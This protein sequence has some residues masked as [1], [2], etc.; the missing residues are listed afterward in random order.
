MDCK[1]KLPSAL[2]KGYSRKFEKGLE[3]MSP[4]EIKNKLIEFA[5]EHTR[6]AFCLFL[7]AGRGNPNWIATVPREAF[8]LLGKFGLEEC[9]R[10]FDLSEGIAGIPV[11]KGIAKRFEDFIQQH[12]VERGLSLFCR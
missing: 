9:R 4:F 10:V 7:N 12:K 1:E 8:F 6:K 3:S 5:E 2:M 11:E